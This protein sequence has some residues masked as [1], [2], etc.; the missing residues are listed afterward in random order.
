V[1]AHLRLEGAGNRSR[2]FRH[3]NQAR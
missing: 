3:A 2:N 1:L